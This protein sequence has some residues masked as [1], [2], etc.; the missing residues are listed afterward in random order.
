M[1]IQKVNEYKNFFSLNERIQK[2]QKVI[3]KY[4]PNKVPVIIQKLPRDKNLPNIDKKSYLIPHD[5]NYSSLL[6][7]LRNK[8]VHIEASIALFLISESGKMLCSGDLMSKVYTD[9]C[10][11]DDKLLYLFYCSE[12]TFG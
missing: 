11:K 7:Y 3:D 10:D 12:N 9:Y 5:M 4:Y 1:R 8:L 6:V 2:S